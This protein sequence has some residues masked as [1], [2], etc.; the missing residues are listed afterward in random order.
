[1]NDADA[2]ERWAGWITDPEPDEEPHCCEECQRLTY[3]PPLCRECSDQEGR[4]SAQA[5]RQE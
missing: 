4:R 5:Q 1:V 2:Y 3:T